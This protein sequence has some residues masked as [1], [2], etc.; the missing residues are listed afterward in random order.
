VKLKWPQTSL[1][2]HQNHVSSSFFP[3]RHKKENLVKVIKKAEDKNVS[4]L[5]SISPPSTF[6]RLIIENKWKVSSHIAGT[7]KKGPACHLL[8]SLVNFYSH[9]FSF[10]RRKKRSV[11]KQCICINFKCTLFSG[12]KWDYCSYRVRNGTFGL[13]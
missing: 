11:D 1:K 6:F 12:S 13:G 3:L 9:N 5:L 2:P 8:I 10:V 4:F 7:H